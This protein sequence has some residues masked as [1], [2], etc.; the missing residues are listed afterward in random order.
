[1]ILCHYQIFSSESSRYHSVI[2]KVLI[3]LSESV[4]RA[5]LARG[6]Y[7]RFPTLDIRIVDQPK[8]C[9]KACLVVMGPPN[10][11]LQ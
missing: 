9:I 1:M 7:T 3:L 10:L 2:L 11:N 8:I 5:S 6:G 4:V